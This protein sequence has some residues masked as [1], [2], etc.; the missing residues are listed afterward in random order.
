MSRA[1]DYKKMKPW[2]RT[3][4]K[5]KERCN[6]KSFHFY[7]RYG[8][9]G[10]KCLI[11]AEELEYLWNRDMAYL[12]A[13]PTIDRI[14]NDGHYELSNCRYV[15]NSFNASRHRKPLHEPCPHGHTD[16]YFT[17]EFVRGRDSFRKRCRDCD[18]AKSKR[19]YE[20]IK[21]KRRLVNV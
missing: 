14:D 11:T 20:K 7:H 15:E 9:R 18:R 5:I 21:H 3:F 13:H 4:V 10:I 19:R 12:L 6:Q 16:T 2:Q 8:G 17:V 1:G